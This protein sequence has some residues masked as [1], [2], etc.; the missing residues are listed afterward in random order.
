MELPFHDQIE[1]LSS[2]PRTR[3]PVRDYDRLCRQLHEE[4]ENVATVRQEQEQGRF[5]LEKLQKQLQMQNKALAAATT[6]AGALREQLSEAN[7]Q[8]RC[9][10]GKGEHVH[11][12][13]VKYVHLCRVAE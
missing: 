7:M 11:E 9:S 3:A 5:E 2:S 6:E 1:A 8:V 10:R 4:R 13:P 12:K